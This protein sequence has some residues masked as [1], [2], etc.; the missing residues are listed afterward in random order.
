VNILYCSFCRDSASGPSQGQGRC[1]CR[2]TRTRRH[3]RGKSGLQKSVHTVDHAL[4]KSQYDV[5]YSCVFCLPADRQTF[6]ANHELLVRSATL[7]KGKSMKW[8]CGHGGE[9]GDSC[10]QECYTL[11]SGVS[12]TFEIS[13]LPPFQATEHLC[14]SEAPGNYCRS[15]R[16]HI[17]EDN[18]S[19]VRWISQRGPNERS[20]NIRNTY[21]YNCHSSGLCPLP[22]LLF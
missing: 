12:S 20:I 2:T 6:A 4:S 5:I 13:L 19:S 14:S 15:A 3:P 7:Y 18:A 1:L 21:S 22:C 9:C 10:L 8:M 16:H 11:P 17:S